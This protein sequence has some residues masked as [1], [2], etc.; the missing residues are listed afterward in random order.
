MRLNR[1]KKGHSLLKED[2]DYRTYYINDNEWTN[3]IEVH[4]SE[5]LRD[6]IVDLLNIYYI[7]ESFEPEGDDER[8]YD[9]A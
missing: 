6:H 8:S 2:A 3:R 5:K 9:N 7:E 1:Y 4:G